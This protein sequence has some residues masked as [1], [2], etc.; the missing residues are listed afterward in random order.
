MRSMYKSGFTL[1]AAMFALSVVGVS[2]ASATLPEFGGNI[3][4]NKFKGTVTLG[5]VEASGGKWFYQ[6]GQ[7]SGEITGAK[8]VANITM[9]MP[10]SSPRWYEGACDSNLEK[11]ELVFSGLKGRLGY[12][13]KAARKV[14]LFFE[15]VKEPLAKC[16]MYGVD[17][18]Y[19]GDFIA[20][21]GP[22]DFSNRKSYTLSFEQHSGI[23]DPLWFEGETE[24]L[25]ETYPFELVD[26]A[27]GK[28]ETG[29][30]GTGALETEKGIEIEG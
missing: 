25:M 12:I 16:Q 26:L 17:G 18:E 19:R 15:P 22:I 29:F 1:L 4:S 5:I 28:T 14:G 21:V 24:K 20:E 3:S 9:S 8:T 13:N 11:N 2:M 7:I 6:K 27:G 30:E 10:N 23:Q